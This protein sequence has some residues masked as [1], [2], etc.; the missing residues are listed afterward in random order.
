MKRPRQLGLLDAT[1]DT[2]AIEAA[3]A[4]LEDPERYGGPGSLMVRWATAVLKPHLNATV[5]RP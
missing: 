2:P 3:K 1:K 5:G 4:I